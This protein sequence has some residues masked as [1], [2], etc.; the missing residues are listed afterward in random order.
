MKNPSRL[1]LI[2]LINILKSSPYTTVPLLFSFHMFLPIAL[3]E[4]EMARLS[5]L[6]GGVPL[7]SESKEQC[8]NIPT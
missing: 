3:S 6:S 5:V 8:I 1:C 2:P 7:K 4:E